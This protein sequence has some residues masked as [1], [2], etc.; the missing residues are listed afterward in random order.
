MCKG[1]ARASGVGTKKTE[2]GQNKQTAIGDK[3]N[4]CILE[5]KVTNGTKKHGQKGTTSGTKGF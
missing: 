2:T 3:I 1:E 5:K 4:K